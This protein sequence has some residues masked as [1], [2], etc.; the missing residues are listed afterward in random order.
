MI[1]P[2]E[3][4]T[5]TVETNTIVVFYVTE[6]QPA[7][8]DAYETHPPPPPKTENKTCARNLRV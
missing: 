2:L 1:R 7:H 6:C 5:K 3:N 8:D 4:K